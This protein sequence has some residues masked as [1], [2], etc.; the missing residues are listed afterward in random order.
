MKKTTYKLTV[1]HFDGPTRWPVPKR[2]RVG[3]DKTAASEFAYECNLLDGKTGIFRKC[4]GEVRLLTKYADGTE[5][6]DVYRRP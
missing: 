6:E 2:I 4:R 3:T 1:Q 5:K